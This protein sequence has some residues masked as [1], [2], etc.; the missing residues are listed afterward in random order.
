MV[1]GGCGSPPQ[2]LAPVS[3]KVTYSDGSPIK[4]EQVLI[5]FLPQGIKD[6]DGLPATAARATA[7]PTDGSFVLMTWKY[8]DGAAIGKHKVTVTGFNPRPPGGYATPKKYI[9]E[10]TSPIEVEVVADKQNYFHI[11]IE[12]GR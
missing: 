10:S 12:K 2:E 4:A 3:G 7:S 1:L 6:K 11:K 5:A 8:G 9:S